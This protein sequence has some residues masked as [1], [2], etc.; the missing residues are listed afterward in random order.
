MAKRVIVVD[1]ACDSPT[2]LWE[3]CDLGAF[4]NWRNVASESTTT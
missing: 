1:G 3:A 4:Q 2:R